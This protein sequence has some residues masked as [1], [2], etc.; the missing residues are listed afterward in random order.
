MDK[1]RIVEILT[2]RAAGSITD[3]ELL[4]LA[5]LLANHPEAIKYEEFLDELWKSYSHQAIEPN[6]DVEFSKHLKR[7]RDKIQFAAPS[8]KDPIVGQDNDQ[9]RSLKLKRHIRTVFAVAAAVI[10]IVFTIYLVLA[11]H[12]NKA[13]DV[14]HKFEY[15]AKKGSRK[16]FSLPDGTRVFLNSDSKL[17]FDERFENGDTRPVVLEGEAYFDV[18][19]NKARPFTITT[20][21]VTIKVVGTA[22][23]I[24]AYPD[25]R[26]T[27]AALI[28]GEIEL[29]LNENPDKVIHM[30]ANDKVEVEDNIQTGDFNDK[31]PNKSLTVRVGNLSKVNIANQEHIAEVTWV[32]GRLVFENETLEELI[33][34]LERW[35]NIRITVTNKSILN[36]HYTAKITNENIIEL[37]TAMQVAKPF[38]YEYINGEITMY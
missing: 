24:K 9:R 35:Y 5:T 8:Y 11:R 33:P 15:I 7:H 4:E 20:H 16:S 30:K 18:A 27:E 34:K 31:Q 38:K 21:S 3:D 23:N 13:K 22:F 10:G 32:E 19:K 37:L 6:I 17:S 2:R 28:R 12:E 25:E 1:D 29:S 26:K 14:Y 36:N